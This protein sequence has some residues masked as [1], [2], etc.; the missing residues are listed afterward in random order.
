VLKTR[1]D[2]TSE[3]FDHY[4]ANQIPNLTAEAKDGLPRDLIFKLFRKGG[5][6]NSKSTSKL[7]F[8]AKLYV[9]CR[10]LRKRW[11]IVIEDEGGFNLNQFNDLPRLIKERD[12]SVEA[13]G[14]LVLS[15]GFVLADTALFN[16]FHY[17]NRLSSSPAYNYL[18]KAKNAP[19]ST[20]EESD[21]RDAYI[22][23]FLVNWEGR[24]KDIVSQTGLSIP[25]LFVLMALFHGVETNGAIFYRELFKRSYQSS[26]AKIK[27]AFGTLQ[28]RGYI[29]KYGVSKGA[30]L[31]ITPVGKDVL[32]GIM[33]KYLLNW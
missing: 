10:A 26:P 14:D 29:V 17:L 7:G 25:E 15:G 27:A 3:N 5:S 21:K 31:Q 30:K 20:V 4:F 1:F 28:Q 16:T 9:L 33:S 23:R 24:K 32:R 18:V 11:F 6:F 22:V 13:A 12:C 8:F 2:A 19:K